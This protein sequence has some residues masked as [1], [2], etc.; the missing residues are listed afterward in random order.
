ML[1]S[2]DG[3]LQF[4][5]GGNTE[6]PPQVAIAIREKYKAFRD[7]KGDV[8]F[9]K[10]IQKIERDIQEIVATPNKRIIRSPFDVY[11]DRNWLIFIAE[12]CEQAD[13]Q[14]RF[15]VHVTPVDVGDLPEPRRRYG[16]E[17]RDFSRS[18]M[19]IDGQSCILKRSLPSYPIRHI[20]TGQFVK[21]AQGSYEHLWEEEFVME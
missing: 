20:R 3:H 19:A 1:L 14:A 21:D 13:L 17:N 6:I 12:E 7:R 4:W 9:K 18:G 11:L 10:D 5:G 15:F 8:I 16:F 2:M